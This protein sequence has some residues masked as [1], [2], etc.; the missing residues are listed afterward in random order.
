MLTAGDDNLP[1]TTA[2]YLTAF[3]ASRLRAPMG[4]A[5]KFLTAAHL[6]QEFYFVLPDKYQL[7]PNLLLLS[8]PICAANYNARFS[9]VKVAAVG[10][11]PAQPPLR[12]LLIGAPYYLLS[13]LECVGARFD[14]LL[15]HEGRWVRPDIQTQVVCYL[16][17]L[18]GSWLYHH[19][20]VHTASNRVGQL[21]PCRETPIFE[22]RSVS[23]YTPL[24]VA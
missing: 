2:G 7:S 8:C 24:T 10:R 14:H 15:F 20:P 11:I 1:V 6:F 19:V 23:L 4:R 9:F 5:G 12:T 3:S 22:Q 13:I 16:L 21:I 18:S 17:W